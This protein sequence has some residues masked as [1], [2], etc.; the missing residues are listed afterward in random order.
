MLSPVGIADGDLVDEFIEILDEEDL[1]V[2]VDLDVPGGHGRDRLDDIAPALFVAVG[3][4]MRA[5][6]ERPDDWE[7]LVD[8][9]AEAVA[10]AGSVRRA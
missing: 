7:S 4:M 6:L 5:P 10:V 9:L 3:S 8:A 1:A 2:A